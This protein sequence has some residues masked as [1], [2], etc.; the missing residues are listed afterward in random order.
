MG[1]S[2][3]NVQRV[4]KWCQKPYLRNHILENVEIRNKFPKSD[5]RNELAK[6]ESNGLYG[7]HLQNKANYCDTT[8]HANHD[9][10][11]RAAEKPL[12]RSFH[13]FDP[14]ADGFLAIVHKA[15][16]AAITMDTPRLVGWAVLASCPSAKC[17]G[18]GTT[19]SRRFGPP[20]N[21]FMMDTDSF[22]VKVESPDIMADVCEGQRRG[23]RRLPH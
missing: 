1:V 11:V 21:S 19:A 2:F 9:S 6:R 20:R 14:E 12:M 18:T 16:G 13:I 8:I 5:P 22:H 4:W 15:K 23:L 7:M 3:D 10:F 17:T